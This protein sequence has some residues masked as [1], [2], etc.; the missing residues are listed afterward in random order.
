M[1]RDTSLSFLR[2]AVRA[3]RIAMLARVPA[4]RASYRRLCRTPL[5][6]KRVDDASTSVMP[7]KTRKTP[8]MWYLGGN[9]ACLGLSA[10]KCSSLVFFLL[11]SPLSGFLS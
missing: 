11:L 7:R 5:S 1:L 9:V 6:V 10:L 8:A 4:C 2:L 3:C